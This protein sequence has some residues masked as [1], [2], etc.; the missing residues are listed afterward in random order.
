MSPPHLVFSRPS[1]S[2]PSTYTLATLHAPISPQSVT[3][4]DRSDLLSPAVV[5][6]TP[7]YGATFP[8][9]PTVPSSRRMILNAALK[10]AAVFIVS[11]LVL[12]GTLW[13]ALPTLEQCVLS[14]YVAGLAISTP[15]PLPS[16]PIDPSSRSQSRSWSCRVS[17]ACSRNI[18][19]FTRTASSCAS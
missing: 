11:T 15:I 8:R 18:E 19:T 9:S 14:F 3:Y 7:I 10:M 2:N 17:M 5:A 13:F 16:A 12:G 1:H 6:T 4:S